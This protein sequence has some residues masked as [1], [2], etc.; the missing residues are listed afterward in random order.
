MS[1]ESPAEEVWEALVH[2]GQKLKPGAGVIFD[3]EPPLHGEVLERRFFGR[4]LIRLWADAGASVREVV[5]RIGHVPLPPYIKRADEAADRERCQTMFAQERG[6]I[7]APTAGLHF[8]GALLTALAQ[9]GIDLV[10]VTLHVGYGTF[11]PVRVEQVEEH[12]LEP[13]AF[14]ISESAAA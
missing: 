3:G 11:Q 1:A 4:R 14:T 8:S 10:E 13:E 2:P 5:D 7:A 9:R 6:S 12:Q